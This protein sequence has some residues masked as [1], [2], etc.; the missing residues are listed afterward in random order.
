MAAPGKVRRLY[1][2]FKGR[3]SMKAHLHILQLEGYDPIR[4]LKWWVRN[5][6]KFKLENKKPLV[7]TGKAK[8]IYALS[9]GFW[10]LMF[11][12]LL[13][14]QPYEIINRWRVKFKTRSKIEKLKA[15]GLRIIGITGSY[16]KTSTKEFLYQI[17]KQK[18]RVLRTPESYNTVFGIA[19]VV[20]LELDNNYDFFIC[21]MGAYKRGEITELCEMVD[22]D[23]GILT[24]INE[25]HLERFGSLENIIKAKNELVD[26]VSKKGGQ[27]VIYGQGEYSHPMEQNIEGAMKMARIL[28]VTK[29]P[30]SFLQP[31]H[32]LKVIERGD[33]LTIIDDAYSANV[34]GF[35]AAIKFLQKFPGYR[36]VVTPGITELGSKTWEIHNKLGKLID[37]VADVVVMVGKNERTISLSQSLSPKKFEFVDSVSHWRKFVDPSRKTVLLFEN[38]LPDNY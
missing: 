22:P 5:M 34:N 4:F 21:E 25:Q 8:Y 38:D 19:K 27:M 23:Y 11:V 13:I 9:G 2:D 14:L 32:R 6:F 10:P 1:K 24:G 16:G 36:V 7:W 3:G 17:L 29:Q 37:Q 28:G 20:D 26:Y 30:K 35:E 12:A 18:Y 31:E 15:D 33:N